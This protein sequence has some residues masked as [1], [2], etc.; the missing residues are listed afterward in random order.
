MAVIGAHICATMPFGKESVLRRVVL[1]LWFVILIGPACRRAERVSAAS[2]G[3][4]SGTV[5]LLDDADPSGVNLVATAAADPAKTSS[6]SSNSE[7]FYRIAGLAAGGYRVE[8]SKVGYQTRSVEDVAVE[9]GRETTGVD[10]ELAAR[11]HGVPDDIRYVSGGSLEGDAAQT[12]TAGSALARPFVVR[13]EDA[14]DDPLQGI[15]ISWEFREP[16]MPGSMQDAGPVYTGTDGQAENICI[17]SEQAGPNRVRVTADGLDGDFVDFTANGLP[18]EPAALVAVRGDDQSGVAGQPLPQA[19]DV[20]VRD[21]FENA[22]PGE[23]VSFVPSGDGQATPSLRDTDARGRA[24]T[25]WTLATA[26]TVGDERQV[27]RAQAG[28]L[29]P[30]VFEAS[31]DHGTRHELRIVGGN[32]QNSLPSVAFAAPLVVEVLDRHGNPVDGEPVDFQ[33]ASG[34]CTLSPPGSQET[35]LAGRAGVTATPDSAGAIEVTAIVANLAPVTFVLTSL[36]GEP[37]RLRVTGGTGQT[38]V[39][40]TPLDAPF[41]FRVDDSAGNGLS[42]V[43]LRFEAGA[44]GGVPGSVSAADA[45]TGSDG[46]AAVTLTLGS[47]AG[48]DVHFVTASLPGFEQVGD[49][50][51]TASARAA[52]PAAV[53]VASGNDQVGRFGSPLDEPLVALVVDGYDNPAAGW[54]VAWS[55][56][57]GGTVSPNPSTVAADGTTSVEATLGVD[58]AQPGQTFTASANGCSAAFSATADGYRVDVLDPHAV[59]PG[60]PDPADPDPA[61]TEVALGVTGAGFPQDMV[62]VWD[63]GGTEEV[64]TPDSVTG[65]R[66]TFRRTAD[67]F[68]PGREGVYP[69]VVRD[70]YGAESEPLP[71]HVKTFA[72]DTGQTAQQCSRFDGQA[73]QWV[74]CADIQPGEPF[75]GQDGHHQPADRQ[76]AFDVHGDGTLT[77]RVT[78]LSWQRCLAGRQGAG[79]TGTAQKMSWQQAEIYCQELIWA[80]HDDWRL[81]HIQQLHPL[82][83]YG[84]FDTGLDPAVFPDPPDDLLGV[85]LWS[86]TEV[87]ASPGQGWSMDASDGWVQ[88]GG[89]ADEEGYV[90]CVRGGPPADGV[91]RIRSEPVA[92][93]PVVED[94]FTGLVWQG[95][96]AGR[97]G[98]GCA[99]GTTLEIDWEDG[100]VYCENLSWGGHDDWRLPQVKE[101]LGIID[102]AQEWPAIDSSLF[103]EA[104]NQQY[105]SSTNRL[106]SL[107]TEYVWA[108]RF[109]SGAVYSQEKD[110]TMW[111]H[112][113]CVRGGL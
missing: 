10:F 85:Y 71:F 45:Q 54:Q 80:G 95:C 19:I 47:L 63:A 57:S 17:L 64:I 20:E 113:R 39:A 83:F 3:S 21:R 8:A 66:I 82:A 112:V 28:T 6:A 72:P 58:P 26:M 111:S 75:F 110:K 107:F 100:L 22:V 43:W 36:P 7:G 93:E 68:A 89:D 48:P 40:G 37:D 103:P 61:A 88:E 25:V 106:N 67:H 33:V 62:V 23:E 79:C 101:L 18:D 56:A 81:P 94:F 60:Y 30:L 65:D 77:D 38:G 31:A 12:G 69:V 42:D 27:L 14:Y 46:E 1:C 59:Y 91:R 74:D 4:I 51:V 16:A 98:P 86:S 102:Y 41:V 44:S 13:V 87:A 50:T 108:V 11:P 105:L 29:E 90:R 70:S 73:W 78:L 104:M 15:A 35:D 92:G 9:A 5:R 99:T 76:P 34:S 97:S 49:L 32:N 96:S 55:S 109:G 53:S 24:S 52:E 2:S 84:S